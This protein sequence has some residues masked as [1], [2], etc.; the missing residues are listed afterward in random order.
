MKWMIDFW[1]WMN[2]F[3]KLKLDQYNLNEK[4]WSE[5]K[6]QNLYLLSSH[7]ILNWLLQY[8]LSRFEFNLNTFK[9]FYDWVEENK[10][11]ILFRLKGKENAIFK[12]LT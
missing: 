12:P 6:V 10:K 3:Q 1:Y 11:S 5:Q 4:A 2:N 9:K 7:H 8:I